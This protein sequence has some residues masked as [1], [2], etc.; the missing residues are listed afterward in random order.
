VKGW[1]IEVGEGHASPL[2]VNGKVF[3]HARQG[4][5][6]V[7]RA[8]RLSDGDEIWKDTYSA[9]YEMS[10][11]A[12]GHG[13]GPKST[14]VY[15]NGMLFTFSIHG[16]L[17]GYNANTGKVVWRKDFQSKF[18]KTS[19]EFGTAMSPIVDRDTVYAHV[20]GKDSGA[21]MA[22]NMK[23]GDVRWT[24][25][26]DGPAYSSPVVTIIDGV[27]QLITQT[28]HACIGIAAEGGSL[29]WRKTFNTPYEQNSVSP[30][31]V[32]GG[33]VFGGI[34]QPTFAVRPHLEG[35]TWKVDSLWSTRDAILYMNTPVL[36][37]KL[38]YGMSQKK[39]GQLFAME[40]NTGKVV[41]VDEG[42]FGDNAAVLAGGGY[43]FALSNKGI[44]LIFRKRGNE[45]VKVH[46]A[47]VSNEETWAT[48]AIS[49]RTMLI[50][51]K[52]TLTLWKM[53]Q[54]E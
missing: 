36:S 16:V 53:A 28:Q 3:I 54:E 6:E 41:W 33:V 24:W 26:G 9:P 29:L 37:G 27:R 15:A 43:I 31:L 45:L 17:T 38:L 12:Q 22:F 35:T 8:L 47:T 32:K 4:E 13:K 34:G 14:P 25:N 52:T 7:V 49:T 48:P 51:D 2:I 1:S 23:N 50:K 39:Q 42:R 46:Q 30:V 11:A 5:N 19:P 21:L 44:L 20:G 10:P 18:A 40:P